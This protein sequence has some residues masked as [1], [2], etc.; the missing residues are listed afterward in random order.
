MGRGRDVLPASVCQQTVD[1]LSLDVRLRAG[2]VL[3][4]LRVRTGFIEASP[5]EPAS[6]VRWRQVEL[7]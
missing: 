3:L 1:D 4:S 6:Q 5:G 2:P 7:D